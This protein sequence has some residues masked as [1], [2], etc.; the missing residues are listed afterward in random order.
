MV[1]GSLSVPP[2][3][4]ICHRAVLAGALAEGTTRIQ[5]WPDAEDCQRTLDVVKGLGVASSLRGASLILEGKGWQALQAPKADLFCGES[6]TTLR[7][8]A[9]MLAGQPFASRLSA[10]P[11]LARRPMR[12]IVTPLQAM[13]ARITGSGAAG[14]ESLPPLA[15]EG[16]RPLKA[17]HYTLP[18]ASAQVKSAILFAALAADGPST[19][20][21]LHPTRD[22]TERMLAAFGADVQRKPDGIR[23]EPSA[24][25]SPGEIR[26]PGDSSSAA[27][28]VVAGLLIPGSEILLEGVGLNPTRIAFLRILERMGGRIHLAVESSGVEPYGQILVRSQ[29]LQPLTLKPT[30]VPGVIDELPILMVACACASGTSE[31]WGL[32]EL[33]FK[34][35]DR[36]ASM[37]AGLRKMGVSIT[38]PEHDAVRIEGGGLT[39]ALVDSADDHRTAM[40]LAVAGLAAKGTTRIAGAECVRKS[41]PGFFLDLARL[42]PPGAVRLPESD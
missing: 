24:L 8:A 1:K 5:P 42:A 14:D 12:R 7:L 16:R 4:A 38:E 3:K 22:H 2:D 13:G 34:E 33:R 26:I 41:Y 27:F 35:T 30:E 40:S 6:G 17:L 9:G 20:V 28:F 11:S 25:R 37:V 36:I 21:E 29:P 31:L 19:V 23:I 15:I 18:V 39:G 32:S 10:A